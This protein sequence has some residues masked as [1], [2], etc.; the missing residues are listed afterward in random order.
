MISGCNSKPVQNLTL[1]NQD[2]EIIQNEIKKYELIIRA[3]ELESLGSIFTDD[4]VFIRPNDIN[5]TGIEDLLEIHYSNISAI[6]GFW[7][8][9]IEINGSGQIAYSFGNYG[10]SEGI[11][12][13]KFM[14]VREKQLDGSWPISRLIWNENPQ[15]KELTQSL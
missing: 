13:G 9:A 2:I 1:T 7:K 6:P 10:F 4:I 3:C 14:E 5:I 8:S 12:S 15:K 11:S